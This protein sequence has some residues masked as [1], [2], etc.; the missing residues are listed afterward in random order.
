[1]RKLQYLFALVLCIAA[2]V[3]AYAQTRTPAD[4]AKHADIVRLMQVSGSGELGVQVMDNMLPS[5]MEV[6]PQV[7]DQVW[8][9]LR[10]EISVGTLVDL[11]VPVYEQHFTHDEIKELIAFYESPIGRKLVQRLP[12]I[13]QESME[14]GGRWGEELAERILDKLAEKGYKKM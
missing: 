4:S 14:I 10:Q 7:P 12:L 1:M 9:E 5:F 13:L 3:P 2:F 8:Q 11:I 6:F